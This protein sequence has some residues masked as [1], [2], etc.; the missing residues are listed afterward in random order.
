MTTAPT[1][2]R[3]RWQER[4]AERRILAT[5]NP[6]DR[7]VTVDLPDRSAVTVDVTSARALPM[8][9]SHLVFTVLEP[10]GPYLS[11]EASVDGHWIDLRDCR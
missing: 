5:A 9:L 7:T 1:E 4:G 6:T 3:I 11:I 2:Y 8:L 10:S